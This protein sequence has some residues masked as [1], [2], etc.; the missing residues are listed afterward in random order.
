MQLMHS[1]MHG[2]SP[3]CPDVHFSRCLL[4]QMFT[5]PD[6]YLSRCSPVQQASRFPYHACKCYHYKVVSFFLISIAI[7]IYLHIHNIGIA[8]T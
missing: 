8:A 2:C 3:S 6:V 1:N 4:V 5:S 7:Y